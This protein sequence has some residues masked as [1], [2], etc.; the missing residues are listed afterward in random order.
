MPSNVS[1]YGA[2]Y[3]AGAF[4]GQ[5][6]ALPTTY[7][8]AM[9]TVIPDPANSGSQL[10]EPSTSN[11]YARLSITNTTAVWGTV[12]GGVVANTAT[13]SFGV[14]TTNDWGSI[15]GYALCDAATAGNVYLYGVLETPRYVA[16]GQ[17]ARFDPGLLT[18]SVTGVRQSILA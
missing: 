8:L 1:D 17:T 4:F 2:D 15:V 10:T 14:A 13:L 5:Q 12:A 7:Y 18:F 6:F 16:V 9:L 11:G 3:I